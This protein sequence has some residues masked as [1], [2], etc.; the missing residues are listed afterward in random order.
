MLK[1]TLLAP[2]WSTYYDY[3]GWH[4]WENLTANMELVLVELLRAV[5]YTCWNSVLLPSGTDDCSPEQGFAGLG[6][7]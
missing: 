1:Y 7:A 5:P 3:K 2:L 6:F 4:Q